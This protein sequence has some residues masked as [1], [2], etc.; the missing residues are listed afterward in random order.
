MQNMIYTYHDCGEAAESKTSRDYK[1]HV[2]IYSDCTAEYL[3]WPMP[4]SHWAALEPLEA[5]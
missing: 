5:V 3:G 1:W 4:A 2:L